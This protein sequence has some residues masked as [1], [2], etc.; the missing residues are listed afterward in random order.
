MTY[1]KD[2]HK[3]FFSQWEP[4]VFIGGM[5][6]AFGI[7]AFLVA[8][9]GSPLQRGP[10]YV[11]LS[12]AVLGAVF[13][14]IFCQRV[15]FERDYAT[16]Y[17]CTFF[18][19]RID[20]ADVAG[21]VNLCRDP[22]NPGVISCVL[23]QLGSSMG[24]MWNLSMFAPAVRK[25]IAQELDT[26]IGI[27]SKGMRPPDFQTWTDNTL[28][29]SPA[30]QIIFLAA[31]VLMLALGI[32]KTCGQLA[33]DERVRAWDKADGIILK[34]TTKQIVRGRHEKSVADVAYRYVYKG[35]EYT[36][37]RIVYDSE[38]FPDLSVGTH[39]QVIVN[40][41][42]PQDCA[43]MFRYR[44]HRGLLRWADCALFF[45][46]AML[47]FGLFVR[48]L[49][50]RDI[51]V[52]DKLK[53]Y[54]ASFPPD[55]IDA[56]MKVGRGL[57]GSSSIVLSRPMEY[58]QD[59]RFG[60]IRGRCSWSTAA[61]FALTLILCVIV[62][63]VVPIGWL[64]AIVTVLLAFPFCVPQATVFDFHEKRICCCRRFDPEKL[65][66]MKRMPFSAADHL[67]CFVQLRKHGNAL[68]CVSA[69][70]RD[71]ISVPLFCVDGKH[72]DLLFD[73][74]PELAEKMG[75]LPVTYS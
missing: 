27:P 72:L 50:R 51:T 23:F 48:G 22:K 31:A 40:P 5:L 15:R 65:K 1:A 35:R 52:P 56:A 10:A 55:R 28:R 45:G 13:F 63:L 21:M 62:S 38:S 66:K 14:P 46:L 41:S 9:L 39:R 49:R 47:V 64:F 70:M 8:V 54:L 68:V 19:V 17:V 7:T 16:L 3:T 4:P 12:P 6:A 37:T 58:R 20:Y 74:L 42:D 60:I 61:V 57:A 53:A 43:I 69:V 33:W 18:P 32:G 25:K 2:G 26:R 73:L 75:H 30:V 67:C 59:G 11:L 24:K 71:G 36:G 44:G 34:N 29:Q